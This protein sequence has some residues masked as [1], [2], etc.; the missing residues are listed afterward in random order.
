M[1]C[2]MAKSLSLDCLPY[3]FYAYMLQCMSELH[4]SLYVQI[5]SKPVLTADSPH[6]HQVVSF[7]QEVEEYILQPNQIVRGTRYSSQAVIEDGCKIFIRFAPKTM[8]RI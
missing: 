5:T 6:G 7:S 3:K 2:T 4:Q 1:A 8:I